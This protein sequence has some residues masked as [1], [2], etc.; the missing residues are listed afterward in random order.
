MNFATT[1]ALDLADQR[2]SYAETPGPAGPPPIVLLHG[3][4]VDHRMWRPQATAFDDRRVIAPDARGHGGSS[5]ASAT[6][7]LAD[8]VI[9]LLDALGIDRAVL[10]GVSMGGGTAVDVA[11]EYP[12]RV[13]ALVVSGTGTSEAEFTD[14]WVLEILA[15]WS[16]AQATGDAEAWIA[17]FMR[18]THGPERG[19]EDV[20]PEVWTLIET[21][22]REVLAHHVSIGDDGL[23]VAPTPPTPVAGTWDRLGEIEVPVLALAGALDSRDH[24]ALASRLVAGVRHGE[25]QEIAGSAHYPNL[26]SPGSF[27]GAI[28]ELLRR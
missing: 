18:F 4:G 23:P 22:V 9:A 25:Y 17:A 16:S 14:P 27:T 13:A 19:P 21:M 24:R 28:V 1:R 12:D 3:G 15:E 20:D 7:R 2:I 10:V 11:L 26:E 6:Y 5:D 8:D